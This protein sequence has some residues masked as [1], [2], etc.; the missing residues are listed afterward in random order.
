MLVPAIEFLSPSQLSTIT[1][2]TAVISPV[3]SSPP[4]SA[5]KWNPGFKVKVEPLLALSAITLS[6]A[7]QHS[8]L[9]NFPNLMGEN[10]HLCFDVHFF[11]FVKLNTF[12]FIGHLHFFP[13]FSVQ[14]HKGRAF[15]M[16]FT[17][18]QDKRLHRFRSLVLVQTFPA[19]CSS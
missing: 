7:L 11:D 19:I 6:Q 16:V 3:H 14:V 15:K 12:L 1:V 13:G 10:E 18:H 17:S 2:N 8:I 5:H 9:K 4:Q